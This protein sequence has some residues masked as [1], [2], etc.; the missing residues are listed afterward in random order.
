MDQ[1]WRISGEDG[2]RF[3]RG[4][5]WVGFLGVGVPAGV[6][7]GSGILG[8]AVGFAAALIAG[9]LAGHLAERAERRHLR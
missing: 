9:A 8:A 2:P 6:V 1:H 4:M 3:V 7:T 5:F